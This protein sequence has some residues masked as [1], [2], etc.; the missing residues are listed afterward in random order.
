MRY[1]R[2]PQIL[3]TCILELRNIR[4]KLQVPELY[5]IMGLIML[6]INM[7]KVKHKLHCFC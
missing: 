5:Q 6:K 4:T 1:R 7:K 2:P 3:V